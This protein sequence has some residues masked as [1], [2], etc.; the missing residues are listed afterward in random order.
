MYDHYVDIFVEKSKTDCYR[1]ENYVIM[2][3]LY[4]LQCPVKIV[5]SYLREAKIDLASDMYIFRP[6]SF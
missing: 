5:S 2:S 1:K 4:S 6:I 3:R